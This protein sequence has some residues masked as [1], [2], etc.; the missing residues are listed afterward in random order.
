MEKELVIKTSP[1]EVEIALLE[2]M[3][4][5]EVHSQKTNSS[6]SVGDIFLASAKKLMPGLNA[7]FMDI[8]HRKDAFLHY[9]DLGPQIKSLIK[10]TNAVINGSYQHKLL[11]GFTLEPDNPK[12]GK[13][14]QVFKKNDMVLVQVLKEPISTKGPRLSCELTLPGR[15]VVLTPFSNIVAVS[16]KIGTNDERKRLK[17]LVDSIKPKNFGVIVRT[18][19]EGKKVAD[20]HND[21]KE[22]EAKWNTIFEQLKQAKSPQKIL[23]EIDKTSSLLR[24]ILNDNFNKIIIDNKEMYLSIRE[25]LQGIAP[26][27]VKIL[28]QYK[29]NRHIFDHYD[30]NRQIK[31]SFGK[32]STMS[33]GAY[34]IIEHTE[35]MHVIDVNSG[36]KMVKKDQEE[37]AISVNLEA[38]EEIA[39]QLRLR[40]L[41]GLIIID[42]IDMRT[43]ENKTS[44]YNKMREF[45]AND[46]AQHTVLPLSKFG[47][48]QITRQ[49][50]R[51]EVNIDT[52]EVC[53]TCLGSGKVNPSIL[54]V[55]DME[56]DLS[57]IYQSRP[58]SKVKLCCNQYVYAFL[59]SGFPSLHMKWM[60][61]YKKWITLKAEPNYHLYEYKFYDES[62]DEI[63]LS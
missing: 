57:Y 54:I 56:R 10:Y 59:K 25:Y 16:K 61:K 58:K 30:I 45:M 62:D 20:L 34:V 52:S 48:M 39:R 53:P 26:D 18:A 55:D 19:A 60:W 50:T 8:G 5:V 41:G 21:I 24:D 4:L 11:D 49:R 31:A 38:A 2:D 51:P 32:T 44:L 47:L 28:T 1:S 29:G 27:K 22:L 9:T 35:A 42:F 14:D 7:G 17:V 6:S 33:S 36:P 15:Y 12:T 63:R 23:S 3:K 43:S 40:D 46:R 37:A 13:I